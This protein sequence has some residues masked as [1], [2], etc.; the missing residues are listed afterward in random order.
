MSILSIAGP[1]LDGGFAR[2]F[3]PI[4]GSLLEGFNS[5]HESSQPQAIRELF[6]E[7]A[8]RIPVRL[9]LQMPVLKYNFPPLTPSDSPFPSQTSSP[10]PFLRFVRFISTKSHLFYFLCLGVNSHL[11]NFNPTKSHLLHF[12]VF[13]VKSLCPNSFTNS[14]PFSLGSFILSRPLLSL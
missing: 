2:E 11:A 6:V 12:L 4:I 5:L 13:G 14:V 3:L 9:S 10:P 1:K 8:L 7:L